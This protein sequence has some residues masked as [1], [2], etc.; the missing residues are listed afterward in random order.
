MALVL[1]TTNNILSQNDKEIDTI[2]PVNLKEVII[3]TPFKQSSVNNI[4]KV[5]RLNTSD[6]N[7]T[8]SQN[9]SKT[10]LEMPGF[11]IISTGPGISKPVIRGLSSNRVTVFNQFMRLENQQWG[12]EHGMDVAAFGVESI[13][14]IMGPMSVLYGSDAIVGVIYINPDSYI[15]DGM[16]VEVSSF[17]NSNYKG[18]TTNLGLKGNLN[19]ISY[20]IQGSMVDN[21][22]FETPHEKIEDTYFDKKDFKAGLGFES[23]NFISDLRFNISQTK[24]G[25]P[26]GD[27]EHDEHGDE[28][29]G[30]EDHGDEDHDDEDHEDEEHEEE[31]Y[32]D[33]ENSMIT[34]KNKIILNNKS[35]FD[36]TLGYS[37][38]KRKEF[39]HHDEEHEDHHDEDHGDED[40]DDEDHDDEHDEHEGEAALNMDLKTTTVD[41]KYIFPKSEKS[42]FV[43]GTSMLSQENTNMGEEQL[44]PDA[45]KN[46]FGFYGL[47]NFYGKTV[48]L[49]VGFRADFRTIEKTN[50]Q[51]SFSSFT[52]SLGLKKDFDNG[53]VRLNFSNGYRAPN[54][55]ELFSDGIHHG[56]ARYEIGDNNL[57][58]EKNFQTDLSI[59]TFSSDS[60]FGMDIFYNS[61]QDYIYLNPTRGKMG[62]APVYNYTQT[63]AVLYGGEV[64]YNK[65]T[66][67]DW[68]SHKTSLAV[69]RGEKSNSEILPFIPPLTLKHSFDMSFG[70]NSFQ[71]SGLA[72]G[73]KENVSLFETET[74]SYFVMDLSGSHKVNLS[75]NDIDISWSINN[76][77]DKEYF[78]HLSRFKTLGIHEMGRNIS[79]GINYIF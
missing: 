74:N 63:N 31:S 47:S 40:H 1:L 36:V 16:E 68:L 29:H 79:I 30:D 33:L 39:G 19:K 54:L 37:Q 45:K 22:D 52:T 17:Y 57:E 4:L 61:I 6:I 66:S 62:D 73:K 8:K 35:E 77:F 26:H 71:I 23:D 3:S 10:L 76:L 75:D 27:E 14:I 25:I 13:E 18:L 55:S 41:V 49:F 48:D 51:K 43:F 67:Y 32:Q 69:V 7:I 15:K 38:N 65:E 21:K 46:D 72:K 20:L 50:Y 34:W 12:D 78:D 5:N 59:S 11:D 24:I 60:Q 56:T 53:V 44:V 9:L 28:D 42:D 70:K 2:V 64:F 58:E